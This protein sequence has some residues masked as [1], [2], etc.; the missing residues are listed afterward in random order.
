MLL[1]VTVLLFAAVFCIIDGQLEESYSGKFVADSI[2]RQLKWTSQ[3]IGDTGK[4]ASSIG[5]TVIVSKPGEY[6][7]YML[8]QNA[9]NYNQIVCDGHNQTQT[10]NTISSIFSTHEL[11]FTVPKGPHSVIVI[12]ELRDQSMVCTPIVDVD[13]FVAETDKMNDTKLANI[14]CTLFCLVFIGL[15]VILILNEIA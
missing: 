6:N 7:A 12:G 2:S 5:L 4:Y 11:E 15:V 1:V 14:G 13:H 8:N 10:V 9:S 3:V